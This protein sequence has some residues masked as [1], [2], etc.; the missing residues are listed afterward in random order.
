M[1]EVGDNLIPVLYKEVVFN[2]KHDLTSS[3]LEEE[4]LRSIVSILKKIRQE[5][6]IKNVT[7][8][9]PDQELYIYRTEVPREAIGDIESAV[10]FGLEE[11][12]PFKASEVNFNYH[13]SAMSNNTVE[14]TVNVFPRKIIQVYT[15][16]IKKAGLFPISFTPE[17]T[18]VANALV[19]KGDEKPYLLVKIEKEHVSTSV[20]SGGVVQY[21]SRVPIDGVNLRALNESA[22]AKKLSQELNKTLIFWFTTN[23]GLGEPQKI[24]EALLVGECALV[25]GLVDYLENSLKIDVELGN[26]WTNCFSL[27][28]YIPEMHKEKSLEYAGPIGLSVESLKFK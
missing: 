2:N 11:N 18:A 5:Y 24:Q 1:K 12:V 21:A 4:E 16:V 17:S 8:I 9:L 23:V 27:D 10:K 15:D 20:V 25:E 28:D 22:E 14:V 26:V 6:K 3:N 19:K 13:I 7:T